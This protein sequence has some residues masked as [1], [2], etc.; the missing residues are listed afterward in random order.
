MDSSAVGTVPYATL[1]TFSRYVGRTGPAKASFVG[2]LR[3]AR[4]SR[5][6]FNP[7]ASFVKALKSDIARG[8][9]RTDDLAVA[10]VVDAVQPRWQPLYRELRDGAARW[11]A[12]LGDVRLVPVRDAL[13]V[14]GGLTVKVNPHFGLRHDDGRLEAVRL[15]FDPQPPTPDLLVATLRLLSRQMATILPG[16]TPVVL[17]VRRGLAY[18]PDPKTRPA[19]VEAWLAGEALAFSAM[20]R[21]P[22]DRPAVTGLP[23]AQMRVWGARL[24]T[25]EDHRAVRSR[26]R[27]SRY[28]ARHRGHRGKSAGIPERVGHQLRQD[29]QHHRDDHRGAVE[30]R[31]HQPGGHLQ[32]PEPLQVV[33]RSP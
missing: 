33:A 7:H 13:D 25:W 5:S 1:L 27:H 4:G 12:G 16:A 30:L 31:R 3:R 9:A 11:L 19:D 14:V 24:R 6:G 18:R 2:S 26:S 28:L 8:G 29:R 23:D 21:R 15:H 17:D 10:A 22:P 20:W 32:L